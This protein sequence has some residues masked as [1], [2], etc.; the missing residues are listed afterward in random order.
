MLTAALFEVAAGCPREP[1]HPSCVAFLRANGV[2]E[3]V[4][5]MLNSCAFAGSLRIGNLWLSRLPEADRENTETQNAPCLKNGFLIVGS[6][7]NG[8]PIA[9]ELRTGKVA[10]ISHDDLWEDDYDSF[11]DLVVRTPLAFEEFYLEALSDSNFPC[12]SYDAAERW[13]PPS[14]TG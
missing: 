8:D 1:L 9:L 2:P 10:F 6:G 11:Q 13:P 14:N 12:D 7:L 4:L 5:S 3:D